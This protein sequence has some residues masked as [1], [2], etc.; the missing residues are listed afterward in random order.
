LDIARFIPYLPENVKY[1]FQDFPRSSCGDHGVSK[2]LITKSLANRLKLIKCGAK[3]NAIDNDC[4][5]PL[6]I[7]SV[8]GHFGVVVA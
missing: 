1:D 7:A 6:H 3:V 8:G 2:A 5:T 4:V